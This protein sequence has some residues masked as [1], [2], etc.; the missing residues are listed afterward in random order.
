M[1]SGK[2]GRSNDEEDTL[3]EVSRTVY[4]ATENKAKYHEAARIAS[5]FGIKLKHLEV[6]KQEIQ[7]D[8]LTQI[9]SFAAEQAAKARRVPVVSEDA[10]F[11]VEA[12]SGFPGP[13]SSYVYR[14]LGILGILKLLK[15]VKMRKA[16]FLAAVAYC[17][18]D[19]TPVC[20][21]GSVRGVVSTKRRGS[22][23]FGFDPIFIPINGDGRTFAQMDITEKNRYSHRARAFV[24]F[25]RWFASR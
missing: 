19:R 12:L 3:K 23:G 25:Y 5:N 18:P 14:T 10:G 7:A 13:Y 9:A 2:C 24:K 21:A 1:F 16:T 8:N 15:N 17:Q 11:F 4:F 22:H 20:F 6:V